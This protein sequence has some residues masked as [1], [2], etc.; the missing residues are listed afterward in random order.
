MLD[1]FQFSVIAGKG[2][3]DIIV[4]LNTVMFWVCPNSPARIEEPLENQLYVDNIT[5]VVAVDIES[6]KEVL[7]VT[8]TGWFSFH[9]KHNTLPLSSCLSRSNRP[10]D[11]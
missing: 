5:A 4:S 11:R 3:L 6:F 8:N 9:T 1:L 7:K 2:Q 10:P